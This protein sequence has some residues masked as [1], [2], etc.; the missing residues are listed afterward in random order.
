MAV[1][2][3]TAHD[4]TSWVDYV[5]FWNVVILLNAVC[6][7]LLFEYNWWKMKRFRNPNRELD[8]LYP[9]YR[10]DDIIHW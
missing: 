10:R 4:E 2:M 8:E 9:C 1:E 5:T 6:G 3:H 7:I